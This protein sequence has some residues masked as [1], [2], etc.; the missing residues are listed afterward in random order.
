ELLVLPAACPPCGGGGDVHA[1]ACGGHGDVVAVRL[2]GAGIELV[3]AC[4]AE[5]AVLGVREVDTVVGGRGGDRCVE[6][7][8][9]GEGVGVTDHHDVVSAVLRHPDDSVAARGEAERGVVGVD[10]HD[11][12]VREQA[13]VVLDGGGVGVDA[14]LLLTPRDTDQDT[15]HASPASA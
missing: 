5:R 7:V 1:G 13:P 12:G 6:R 15:H 9:L 14:V 11:V 3:G 4:L 2:W 10:V 8:G